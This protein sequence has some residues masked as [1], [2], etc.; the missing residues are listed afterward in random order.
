MTTAKLKDYY[1]AFWLKSET[2]E[3]R[4]ARVIWGLG[5][6]LF[7]MGVSVPVM[8]IVK[9][10]ADAFLAVGIVRSSVLLLSAGLVLF[11]VLWLLTK[12]REWQKEREFE[13]TAELSDGQVVTLKIKTANGV[14]YADRQFGGF[15]MG[16]QAAAIGDWEGHI[17]ADSWTG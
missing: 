3:T 13:H 12:P 5:I 11:G 7:G 17:K 8:M 15:L 10:L 6:L 2:A 14:D 1:L 16:C 4:T 9:V